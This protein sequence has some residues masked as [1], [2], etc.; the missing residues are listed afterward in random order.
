MINKKPLVLC[1]L[2]GWGLTKDNKY[3]AI[4]KANP[5][6]FN[7]LLQKYPHSELEASGLFVGLP[8]GQIGN[9]EVGHTNIGAG[10]VIYQDLPKISKAISNNQIKNNKILQNFINSIKK[11]NGNIHL[12]GLLSDGGVHSH[13][14][15]II[16]LAKTLAKENLNIFIHCFLD[17]RDVPQKSA[18]TY[19]NQLIKETQKYKNIKIAT[20]GGRYF[21]MD[22]DDKWDRIEKAYNIIVNGDNLSNKNPIEI[23]EENYSKNITDEFIEPTSLNNYKGMEN[24]D[25]FIF[26]NFRADRA[27]QITKALAFPNFTKFNRKK[28]I[29]FTSK[30]QLTEYSKEN[31]QFMDTLFPSEEIIESLGEII[32]KNNLNQLRIAETEKYAHVTFFFNCGTEAPFKNEERILIKS[33]NVATYDLQPEM[34]AEELTNNLINKI[35][36]SEYDFIVVNFANADMVGHTGIMDAAVKAI[37]TLDNQLEKLVKIV[38]NMDGTILITADHGNAEKMFD[39][40][41]Q[42]PYTAHTI[43]KVP[44]IV[45]QNNINNIKLNNGS[46]SD[47]APTILKLL[48]LKQPEIMSGKNLIK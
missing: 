3:S 21:A 39:E 14:E 47:I 19:L 37:K 45:V 38:L 25:S 46:L 20:I 42:Q 18:I 17:G 34:S 9:S 11:S 24:N 6:F 13:I 43:N 23:I 30:I 7:S 32:A 2:D 48:N 5:I 22:R 26:C 27:R 33:P 15:H 35:N 28:I 16:Y 31:N 29:N 12:L 40:E 10:R 44:F 1:I 36:K 8:D 41:K 4:H